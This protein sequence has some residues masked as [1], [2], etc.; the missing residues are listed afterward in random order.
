MLRPVRPRANPSLKQAQCSQSHVQLSTKPEVTSIG[1]SGGTPAGQ[2]WTRRPHKIT[3]EVAR[4]IE[5]TVVHREEVTAQRRLVER[6][7][8]RFGLVVHQ[9]TV[10]RALARLKKSAV[11]P[12]AGISMVMPWW[13]ATRFCDTMWSPP[14]IAAMRR[15]VAQGSSARRSLAS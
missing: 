9:R 4:Y 7:A 14:Q 15:R 6:I 3:L 2:T 8:E 1:A 5:E 11:T 10:K 13:R 12:T